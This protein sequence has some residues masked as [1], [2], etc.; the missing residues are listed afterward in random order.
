MG[1]LS[2]LCTGE[3]P[4]S[5]CILL[6]A[7]TFHDRCG[8]F[9]AI[10]VT[11]S[12]SVR[13]AQGPLLPPQK[14]RA[15]Q[16]NLRF[17]FWAGRQALSRRETNGSSGLP[18]AFRILARISR[19]GWSF[20]PSV[21]ASSPPKSHSVVTNASLYTPTSVHLELSFV[22]LIFPLHLPPLERIRSVYKSFEHNRT[23]RE[24]KA[25]F[26]TTFPDLSR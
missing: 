5:E 11:V 2:L 8:S 22:L 1:P 7:C 25:L 16:T 17:R 20:H 6:S 12:D 18:S 23:P 14:T 19:A 4:L 9:F 15:G 3:S 26:G 13:G 24:N 10:L 21:A